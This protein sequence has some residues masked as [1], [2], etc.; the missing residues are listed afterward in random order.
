MTITVVVPLHASMR[1]VDNVEANVRALPSMVTEVLLSDRTAVDG[2]AE[3]LRT[4]LADDPRVSV[5]REARGLTWPEHCQLLVE[6]ASGDLAMLMPHDDVFEASWVPVLAEALDHHPRALLAFGR[7]VMVEAE[8]VTPHTGWQP[9]LL[10][11]GEIHG[12]DAVRLVADGELGVP[13]RGLF[14]R[15]EVLDLGIRLESPTASRGRHPGV[16]QLWALAIA[17]RGGLV[18]DDRVVTRKRVHPESATAVF[19]LGAAGSL[20]RDAMA[21]V[22]RHG[23]GGTAEARMQ[24]VLWRAWAAARL[25][26]VRARARRPV[27]RG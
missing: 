8:G 27:V 14:R 7:V 24:A 26:H 21:V 5:V 3:V 1:W 17:L 23:P 15:R 20:Q 10:L 4:R 13:F 12:L 22:R 6:E 11:P 2:A 16:D 25:R 9:R 19:G 18:V